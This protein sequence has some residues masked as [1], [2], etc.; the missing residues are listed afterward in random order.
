MNVCTGVSDGRGS[1]GGVR[2]PAHVAT[3][4]GRHPARH[5]RPDRPRHG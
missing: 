5:G 2:S 1:H 4:R 3:E